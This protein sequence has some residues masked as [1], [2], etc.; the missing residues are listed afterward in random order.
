MAFKALGITEA[1][2]K[3][4][5]ELNFEAPT[6]IQQKSIPPVVAGHDVIAGSKTGSG[7]TLAFT[8]GIMQKVVPGQG[9]QALVMT[10]TREL[11]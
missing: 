11:A 4:I 6:E 9:L 1:L 8:A 10:P 5:A 3:A 7:K 2:A